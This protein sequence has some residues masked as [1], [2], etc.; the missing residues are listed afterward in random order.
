VIGYAKD[1]VIL[2]QRPRR[3]IF[4]PC[5]VDFHYWAQMRSAGIPV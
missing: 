1:M 2:S 5:A 3:H 4:V